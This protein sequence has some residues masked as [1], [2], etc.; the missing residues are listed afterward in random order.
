MSN[1]IIKYEPVIIQGVEKP[2]YNIYYFDENGIQE[3]KEFYAIDLADPQIEIR[4][5]YT[6]RPDSL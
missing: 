6:K 5:G 2:K 1:Y 3:T 4:K